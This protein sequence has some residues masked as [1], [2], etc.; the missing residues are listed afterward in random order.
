MK[1]W[2]MCE[3]WSCVLGGGLVGVEEWE[4]GAMVTLLGWRSRRGRG[5]F[6]R[7]R[8]VRRQSGGRRGGRLGG[9]GGLGCGGA[10]VELGEVVAGALCRLVRV[11]DG[12]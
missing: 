8:H 12:V 9:E 3:G 10:G 6:P 5:W 2:R 11:R 7:W 4:V 1:V